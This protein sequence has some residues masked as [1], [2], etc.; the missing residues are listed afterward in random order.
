VEKESFN[1]KK[2][3]LMSVLMTLFKD[4]KIK[5]DSIKKSNIS[6]SNILIT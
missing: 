5:N 3:L 1:L 4:Y 2:V 6:I